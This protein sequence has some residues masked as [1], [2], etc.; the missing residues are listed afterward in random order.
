MSDTSVAAGHLILE[1]FPL[2]MMRQILVTLLLGAASAACAASNFSFSNTPGPYPVG[3]RVKAQYDYSR[4]Y[5]PKLDI[6]SGKPTS[7]E[8]ARPIQALIWYP[9][10]GKGQAMV[11]RDYLATGP[12][13]D[14]PALDAASVQRAVDAD[15]ARYVSGDRVEDGRRE[16][17]RPVWAQKNA[18][19]RAG[20]FPVVIYAPSFNAPAFENTDLCEYLASR[21]YVVISSRSLGAH[22]RSMTTDLEGAEAQAAD[23]AFL[24]GYAHSLPQADLGHVGVVGFSWGG[25]ANVLAAAKDERIGALVSLDGSMRGFTEFVNGG[26]DAA[27]YV[28]PAR[29]AVPLLYMAKQRYSP[30]ELEQRKIDTTFSLMNRMKY[31]DVYIGTMNPMTHMDFSSLHLRYGDDADFKEYSRDEASLAHS[32]VARYVGHFLDAYLKGDAQSRQFLDR[33]PTQNKVPAHM[34]LFDARH[35]TGEPPTMQT[36]VRIVNARGFEHAIEVYD[37]MH[38]DDASFAFDQNVILAWGTQLMQGGRPKEGVEILKLAT[39]IYPDDA[40]LANALAGAGEE[41]GQRDLAIGSY[42]R[43]LELDPT[44]RNAAERLKALDAQMGAAGSRAAK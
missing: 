33:T 36:F 18:P 27:K 8:P 20:K 25:L 4:N 10:Q 5:K 43:V 17:T 13:E 12:T 37:R 41:A 22:S 26:K 28:T 23:I 34:M 39:H 9:A 30:E 44:N 11:H 19:E 21:G 16:I 38:K 32:W 42:R 14:D 3:F 29:L 35:G 6:V 31:S 7:G 24:I 1:P 2:T 40:Y 15:V